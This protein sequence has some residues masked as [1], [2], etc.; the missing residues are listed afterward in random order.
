[1]LPAPVQG[2]QVVP[3]GQRPQEARFAGHVGDLAGQLLLRRPDLRVRGV[4]RRLEL[5]LRRLHLALLA[6]DLSDQGVHLG[7]LGFQL[8]LGRLLLRF[9]VLL[10]L[11]GGLQGCFIRLDLLPDGDELVHHLVVIVHDL[12]H[13]HGVVQQVGKIIGAEQDG[14]VGDLSLL[15]HLPHPLAEQLVLGPFLFL[16]RRQLRLLLGDELV[17]LG[18][19][20]RDIVDLRLGGVDLLLQQGLLV[21]GLALVR[22]D[23]LQL[24]LQ[25]RPLLL[26]G[27]GVPPSSG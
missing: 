2:G 7:L 15:L 21:Q 11:A 22:L 12:F 17:I 9:G 13:H 1:M 14:P 4:G 19:L 6:A 26:Q 27:G 10:L 5:G 24:L 20:C 8:R 3:A 16:R 18:D 23:G 25:L